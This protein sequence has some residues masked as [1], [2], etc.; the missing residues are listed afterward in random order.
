R[1][2]PSLHPSI[3]TVLRRLDHRPSNQ[4]LAR[5]QH[6]DMRPRT[7]RDSHRAGPGAIFGAGADNNGRG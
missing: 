6:A 5:P 2:S 4:S 3:Q 1:P 7:A